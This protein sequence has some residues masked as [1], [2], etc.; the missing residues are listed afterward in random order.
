MKAYK[1]FKKDMTCRGFRFEEGKT[2]EEENAKLC[3]RGFH[4]CE[5][6]MDCISYYAPN[7]SVY[8][9]VELEGVNEKR[10]KDSKVCAKR[11]TVGARINIAD[12]VKG[13]IRFVFEKAE[14]ANSTTGDGA[15]AATTGYSAHAATTGNWAHAAT[16]GNCAHA[17]TTGKCAHAATTGNCAHAATT[18]NCAHAATTGYS[19]HAATTGDGA[20]AATT[21]ENSIAA[22]LGINSKAKAALGGWIVCAE[23][24][25]ECRLISVAAAKV[26]GETIKADTWYVLEGGGF[27]EAEDDE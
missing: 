27:V 18:G 11:I 22:A 19:A 15:H 26:D 9:E 4:A 20:H 10:D 7:S 13:A 21:G 3:E 5:N 17:A 1:G 14:K 25:A 24:D 12:L 2:Y 16:T 23:Y 6:P 8:H